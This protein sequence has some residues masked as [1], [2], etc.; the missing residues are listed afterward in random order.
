MVLGVH[1]DAW[2]FSGDVLP[3]AAAADGMVDLPPNHPLIRYVGGVDRPPS[4]GSCAS[5]R[6]HGVTECP[7]S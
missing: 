6:P 4:G 1:P 3:S 2:A 7:R 5:R